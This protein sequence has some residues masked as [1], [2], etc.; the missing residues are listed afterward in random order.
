MKQGSAPQLICPERTLLNPAH[1]DAA[2]TLSEQFDT[3]LAT[4]T[5]KAMSLRQLGKRGFDSQRGHL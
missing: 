1:E 4:P 2:I 5:L 3:E